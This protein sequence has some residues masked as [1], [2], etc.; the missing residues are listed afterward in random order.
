[1]P[2]VALLTDAERFPFD[3]DDRAALAEADVE[4]R[5]LPGHDPTEI[6]PAAHGADAIF[7]YH[8]RVTADLIASL[9]GVR[10]IARCGAGFDNIDVAAARAHNIE[11][12]YV[13]DYGIDDIADHALALLLACARKIVLCD[14]SVRAGRWDSYP[15]LAPMHRLRGRTVGVYGYGRIGRN[16]ADKARCLGLNVL[17]YDPY[18][19]SAA[20][21]REELLRESDFIS[22]H[23]PLTKETRHSIGRVE[24]ALMKHGAVLINTARGGIVVSSSLVEALQTGRL[25]G[26]GLDVYE[27]SPLPLDHP[28]RSCDTA[29]LTPHSAAY[30][31]DSLAEVRKRALSDALRVLRR[32]TPLNAIPVRDSPTLA[33]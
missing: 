5:E 33:I 30:T 12:V 15:E 20:A 25:A 4:L 17:A 19:A 8:A 2:A 6:V 10:V 1:M 31:E 32:E 13:P 3:D 22:I 18:V 9:Q 29:V 11:L 7:I 27:D 21:T 28:L 24:F 16:F 14:R 26:A 23:V